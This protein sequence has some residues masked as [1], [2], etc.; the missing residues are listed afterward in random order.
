MRKSVQNNLTSGGPNCALESAHHHGLNV[1][2][3]GAL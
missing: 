3:E 2:L 1:A